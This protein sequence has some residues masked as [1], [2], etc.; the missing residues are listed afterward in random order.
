MCCIIWYQGKDVPKKDFIKKEY[1]P[2][3]TNYLPN[4]SEITNKQKLYE[5]ISKYDPSCVGSFIPKTFIVDFK[6]NL[7]NIENNLS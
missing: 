4:H 3:A 2:K 7:T 5:N 6:D 1:N